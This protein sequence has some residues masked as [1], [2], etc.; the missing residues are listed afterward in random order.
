[1]TAATPRSRDTLVEEIHKL[2]KRKIAEFGVDSRIFIELIGDQKAP[3][4]ARVI[5]GGV[6]VY[7]NFARD[8]LPERWKALGLIDDVIV[9]TIGLTICI[10]LLPRQRRD[11]YQKKYRAVEMLVPDSELLKRVLGI[12]WDRL[13]DYVRG[14]GDRTYRGQDMATVVESEELRERLFDETM[15]SVAK[16]SIDPTTLDKELAKLPAPEKIAGLLTQGMD[17]LEKPDG[18]D[19]GSSP[20]GWARL[21]RIFRKQDDAASE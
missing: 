3:L 18:H 2:L 5:A 11:Y 17:D 4:P 16:A 12:V 20:L 15:E 7:L 1:M 9:M 14:L 21:G 6:L 10:D 13:N 19:Q 8:I